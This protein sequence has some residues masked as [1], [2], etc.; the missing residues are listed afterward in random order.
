MKQVLK[1]GLVISVFGIFSSALAE[2][3]DQNPYVVLYRKRLA[4]A[5]TMV[6]S[7]QNTVDFEYTK[8]RRLADLADIGAV[9]QKEAADQGAIYK[10]SLKKLSIA[11]LKQNS[12][13]AF[14]R[15]AV[16]RV[17]AGLNMEVCP[18]EN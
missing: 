3:I 12:A 14:V 17:Q 18:V 8:W 16:S 10:M 2:D 9:S 1:I 11:K 4:I 7:Q 6:A 15:I 5:K 13:D